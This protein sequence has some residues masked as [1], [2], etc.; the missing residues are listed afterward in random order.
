MRGVEHPRLV[1]QRPSF[2][3]GMVLKSRMRARLRHEY[4]VALTEKP[5][6]NMQAKCGMKMCGQSSEGP[7]PKARDGATGKCK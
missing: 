3:L 7:N 4:F 6:T 5:S 2:H 1:P